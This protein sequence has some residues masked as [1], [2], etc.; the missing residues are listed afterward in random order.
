LA[1]KILEE[2]TRYKEPGTGKNQETR[3]KKAKKR[4]KLQGFSSKELFMGIR[5]VFL[6]WPLLGFFP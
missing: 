4:R 5:R 3:V 6:S 1:A 2:G